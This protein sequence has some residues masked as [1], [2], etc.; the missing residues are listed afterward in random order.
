MNSIELLKSVL[1]ISTSG[2]TAAAV[3]NH[4]VSRERNRK[5]EKVSRLVDVCGN[6]TSRQA[7]IG[8][9]KQLQDSGFGRFIIGRRGYDSRF[10]WKEV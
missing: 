8:V 1:A 7:V 5:V 2:A 10:V 4:V 9:L 6:G 3:I